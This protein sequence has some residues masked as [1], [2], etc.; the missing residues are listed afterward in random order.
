MHRLNV[1]HHEQAQVMPSILQFAQAQVDVDIEHEI[2]WMP[3]DFTLDQR[4]ALDLVGL[5]EDEARL[6]EGEAFD[7][8]RGV[9]TLV[10]TIQAHR[11]FKSR[12]VRQQ[13][14][15]TRALKQIAEMKEKLDREMGTYEWA[16][17]ALIRLGEN[18]SDRNQER[19]PQLTDRDTW[20]K[21]TQSKR[22]LGDS[23]H[24]DGKIWAL[25][26]TSVRSLPGDVVDKASTV[27]RE[28]GWIWQIDRG[29]NID[30]TEVEQWD[31]EGKSYIHCAQCT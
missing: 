22:S 16:R 25:S 28:E 10:K 29:S 7:A 19:F 23:R 27:E 13:E 26:V 20:R 15:N 18:G 9:R 8:V 6:R 24:T 14:A 3:S 2:L 5:G 11:N 12:N 17:Q 1:W 4:R 31:E 21:P 30:E